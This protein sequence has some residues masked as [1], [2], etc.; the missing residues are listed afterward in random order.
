MRDPVPGSDCFK[1]L[2]VGQS[3]QPVARG[4]IEPAE[5]VCQRGGQLGVH[6]SAVGVWGEVDVETCRVGEL[7]T[8][9]PVD[10]PADLNIHPG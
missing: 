2:T 10:M 6:V 4:I 9:A 8:V 5:H 3:L 1:R 7:F